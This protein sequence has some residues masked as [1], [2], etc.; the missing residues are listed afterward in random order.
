MSSKANT[1]NGMAGN[2]DESGEPCGAVC[3]TGLIHKYNGELERLDVEIASHDAAVA[4]RDA[5]VAARN[6]VLRARAEAAAII[7]AE[8]EVPATPSR[9]R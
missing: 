4:V 9:T 3:A 7:A 6:D 8:S 2:E 1:M 5:A